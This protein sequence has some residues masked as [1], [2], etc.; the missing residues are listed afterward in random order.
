MSAIRV[1]GLMC[2]HNAERYIGEALASM[3]R[4]TRPLDEIIV[5][6]DGS[7]DRTSEIARSFGPL[8]RVLDSPKV[9]LARARNLMVESATGDLVA[10][11]DADDLWT[12]N[13]VEIGIAAF[14]RDPSLEMAF[15]HMRQFRDGED[16]YS[17]PAESA[18]LP[19][20][21]TARRSVFGRVGPFN[22]EYSISEFLDWLMRARE[23]RIREALLPEVLL[24]RRIHDS[25]IGVK[26]TDEK[27]RTFLRSLQAGIRRRRDAAS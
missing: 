6:N 19:G 15:C 13:R 1:S 21:L 22:V 27:Y 24:L 2:A 17:K 12:E 3:L 16:P 23:L 8:V 10:V 7:T 9:G 11:L 4:Q 20:G 18:T 25:N 26:Q 14:E 5:V